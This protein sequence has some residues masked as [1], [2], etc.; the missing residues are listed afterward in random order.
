MMY[1]FEVEEREDECMLTPMTL[2]WVADLADATSKMANNT[3]ETY[4]VFN[5]YI[6]EN[7]D[8]LHSDVCDLSNNHL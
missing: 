5:L 3:D 1:F 8:T 4:S 2:S 6:I 7:G